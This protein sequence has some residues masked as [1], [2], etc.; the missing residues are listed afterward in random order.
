ME[1]TQIIE[2]LVAA[3]PYLFG[4]AVMVYVAIKDI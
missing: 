4:I 1:T 3:V 2:I